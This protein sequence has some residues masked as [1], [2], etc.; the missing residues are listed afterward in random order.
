[1]A[2]SKR[3]LTHIG[4]DPRPG[5][6]IGGAAA[7]IATQPCFAPR[8]GGRRRIGIA[9]SA[10]D[11]QNH[12]IFDDRPAHDGLTPRRHAGMFALTRTE[13]GC[14]TPLKAEGM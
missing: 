6:E 1:M 10:A 8:P 14:L 3:A 9:H 11:T 2:I 5:P 4:I 7:E 13:N 12:S